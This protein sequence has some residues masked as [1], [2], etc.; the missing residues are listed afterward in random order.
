MLPMRHLGSAESRSL[1]HGRKAAAMMIEE[2][3]A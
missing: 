1:D 2:I 3:E